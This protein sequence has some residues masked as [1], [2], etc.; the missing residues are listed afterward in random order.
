MNS[1]T[2]SSI[3]KPISLPEKSFQA[4]TTTIPSGGKLSGGFSQTNIK[5]RHRNDDHDR[6]DNGHDY[7]NA[8]YDDDDNDNAFQSERSNRSMKLTLEQQQELLNLSKIIRIE[9]SARMK[10]EDERRKLLLSVK[11][12]LPTRQQQ[13]SLK[14]P[15]SYRSNSSSSSIIAPTLNQYRYNDNNDSFEHI[16]SNGDTSDNNNNNNNNAVNNNFAINRAGN[17]DDAYAYT[18]TNPSID[19]SSKRGFMDTSSS[20]LMGK[21][22]VIRGVGGGGG[23][24]GRKLMLPSPTEIDTAYKW[25]NLSR[26]LVLVDRVPKNY[27]FRV[28]LLP[29]LFNTGYD[30]ESKVDSSRGPTVV[31]SKSYSLEWL[32]EDTSQAT[33]ADGCVL[34]EHIKQVYVSDMAREEFIIQVVC[35]TKALK[36]SNGRTTIIIRCDSIGASAK[37]VSSLNTML[38]SY[39]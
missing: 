20:F 7:N 39:Q 27:V 36:N 30:Y 1:P 17:D 9:E 18:Y 28:V 10:Y 26:P 35:S 21:S 14:A 3:M 12:N 25:L 32:R 6:I 15:A 23:G 19:S 13:A 4:T 16:N 2:P 33:T 24:G 29:D 22:P 31:T 11:A 5:N 34:L 38:R 37:Y 8:D